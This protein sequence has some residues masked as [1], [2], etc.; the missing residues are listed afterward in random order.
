M[1]SW[2]RKKGIQSQ[3]AHGQIQ[4]GDDY[5]GLLPLRTY[6]ERNSLSCR[7]TLNVRNVRIVYSHFEIL[8]TIDFQL[9]RRGRPGRRLVWNR[10]FALF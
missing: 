5:K 9:F 8:R 2:L 10:I 7:Q 4:D 6:R 3:N 1:K